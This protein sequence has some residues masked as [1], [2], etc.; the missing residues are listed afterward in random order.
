[1]PAREA[2]AEALAWILQRSYLTDSVARKLELSPE[3]VDARA[4]FRTEVSQ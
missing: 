4:R 2:L 1:V 3:V